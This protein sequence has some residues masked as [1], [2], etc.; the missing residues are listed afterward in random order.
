MEIILTGGP[1]GLDPCVR[2]DDVV[3]PDR[4]KFKHLNGYEHFERSDRGG[5]TPVYRWIYSTK[6]AE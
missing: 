6:I 3:P 1:E 4:V 5:E 2:I